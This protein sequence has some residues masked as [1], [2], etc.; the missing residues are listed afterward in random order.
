MNR[1]HDQKK[2]WV[3]TADVV[4]MRSKQRLNDDGERESDADVFKRIMDM[5]DPVQDNEVLL[6]R[7]D[8]K[9]L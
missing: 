1:R 6:L 7:V 3:D 5:V 8:K 9:R 4:R 2:I